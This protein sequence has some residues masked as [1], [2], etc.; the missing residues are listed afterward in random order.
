M[1]RARE[2]LGTAP[3]S[4][5]VDWQSDDSTTGL[6][7]SH[8]GY[9]RSHGLV[10]TRSLR[11]GLDGRGVT[12]EDAL[13]V[14]G[15]EARK[16]FDAGARRLEAQGHRLRDPLP[17]APGRRRRTS[18]SAARR[19]RWSSR[20][21]RSGSSATT[22]AR[23][24]RSNPASI[25]KG[26]PRAARDKTDRS[27]RRRDRHATRVGWTIS[28]AQDTPSNIRD[29][30]TDERGHRLTDQTGTP[31]TDLQPCAARSSPSPTRP[32]WSTSARRCEA[33]GRASLDRR[34]LG[35]AA[36]GGPRRAR[37]GRPHRLPR[38]DGRARQ[39]AAPQGPRRASGA[40]RQA[41]A[42]EAMEAHGIAPIDLLVVN[43]YPF[44]ATVARGADY[45]DCIENIDIGGPAMIRAA[46][47]NH[48]FVTVVV[49]RGLR[50][51]LAELDRTA[52]RP[53]S[54][55]AAASRRPPMPA[56]P[57]TT[58]PS[59]PGWPAP[60]ARP[61]RAAAP[62]PGSCARPA[63]RREPAPARRLLHR[64]HRPPRRRH[65]DPVAGQGA[66]L[67]QHQRHRRRLRARLGIPPRRRPGLRDHQARQPLR[68]RPRRDAGR[69]LRPRL[70]LRPDLGLRGDRR[71]Q[72]E[73]RHP[74]RAR[75]SPR[76]S[77]RSSSPPA[78]TTPRR[79][80]FARRRTCAC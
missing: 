43:L 27:L 30:V 1:G 8:D 61:R 51:L 66:E 72:H 24:S 68:R 50:A 21:A 63:L 31:M 77:P 6:L 65:R 28:K 13:D 33:R 34:H 15:A 71:A 53:R 78:P 69:G 2:L 40:A 42:R 62:S 56:P 12:G 59:R 46:A 57:P 67:Q 76:S 49:D 60:S 64:R 35:H 73:A 79:S 54:P 16:A 17:P 29:F 32:G 9:L 20:A 18:T 75:R 11:L 45:D 44:E 7:A 36:R 47:K 52:A 41:F 14:P 70:R 23:R 37:R 5:T 55:S 22:A 58:P 3:R 10:H 26:P 38:D 19:C 39:D 80:M 74:H 25:S 48:A 4:V